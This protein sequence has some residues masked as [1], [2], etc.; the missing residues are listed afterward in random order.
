MEGAFEREV[1]SV[2]CAAS[3]G[4]DGLSKR[5]DAEVHGQGDGLSNFLRLSKL[6]QHPA[7][8]FRP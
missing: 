7:F 5:S 2:T 3:S 1:V 6:Y 4:G 8:P